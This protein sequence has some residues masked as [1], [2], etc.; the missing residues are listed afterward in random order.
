MVDMNDSQGTVAVARSTIEPI[1]DL[2]KIDS[3]QRTLRERVLPLRMNAWGSIPHGG[4]DP[5]S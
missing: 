1:W 4:I 5:T 3:A 2:F